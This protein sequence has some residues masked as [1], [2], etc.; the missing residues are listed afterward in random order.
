MTI[1][2]FVPAL[3]APFFGFLAVV[4]GALAFSVASAVVAHLLGMSFFRPGWVGRLLYFTGPVAR[5]A[6]G[7]GLEGFADSV[8]ANVNGGIVLGA[9]VTMAWAASGGAGYRLYVR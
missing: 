6:L 4:S 5:S 3:A 7:G 2:V 1:L 8:D 9:I